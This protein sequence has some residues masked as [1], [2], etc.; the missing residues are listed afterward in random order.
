M[1]LTFYFKF[2]SKSLFEEQKPR[3][4]PKNYINNTK[5]VSVYKTKIEKQVVRVK[6]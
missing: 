1:C 6:K 5:L 3:L 4:K 2:L